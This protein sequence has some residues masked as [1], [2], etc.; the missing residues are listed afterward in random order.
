MQWSG[1]DSFQNKRLMLQRK[2]DF[3]EQN[4]KKLIL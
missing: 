1:M 4:D 2:F 3:K